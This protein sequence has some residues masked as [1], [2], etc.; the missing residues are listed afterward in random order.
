MGTA[1][2]L[3]LT[4]QH[5]ADLDAKDS[6]VT[7]DLARRWLLVEQELQQDILD[8]AT[9][10]SNMVQAGQVIQPWRL[11]KMRRYTRLLAQLQE[12]LQSFNAQAAVD[13]AWLQ[14]QAA[15]AGIQNHLNYINEVAA[16]YDAQSVILQMDRLGSEAVQNI[17]AVARGG[18]PLD[19]ILKTA[20]PLTA[21][22]ITNKLIFNTAMGRNPRQTAREI[23]RDGLAAGLNHVLLVA[24][25]QQ[26]RA[27]REAGRQAYERSGV[28]EAYRRLCAKSTRTCL[29]CLAM[30]G[31]IW[32]VSELM[33]L[34]PQ[35]RCS[36]IPIVNGLPPV[37]FQTG[38]EWFMNQPEATQRRMMGPG[39]FE[40]WQAGRFDFRQLATVKDHPVWGPSARVTAL[41]D[42]LRGRGG[43]KNA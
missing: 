7:Q 22:A 12:Q 42:L 17:V 33:A 36:Q 15:F 29:A 3:S 11:A 26:I 31:T 9:E 37:R 14:N 38:R 34:H 8:L 43:L 6:Q 39:T 20:Y 28:V 5:Q 19:R 24:R 10:L 4:R 35:D 32:P 18:G 41:R 1:E 21:N 23:I 25:D 16:F 30:D 27:Y 40:A 13:I 2:I